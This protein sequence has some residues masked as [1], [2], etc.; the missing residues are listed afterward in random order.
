M[1]AYILTV[2]PGT[3][4]AKAGLHP[5]DIITAVDGQPIDQNHDLSSVIEMH[6]PGQTV[7]LSVFRAGQKL[8]FH[9]KLVARP[10][11]V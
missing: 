7:T 10:K 2:E 9:I 1:G 4:A 8:T 3:P 5:R 6:Q 11:N